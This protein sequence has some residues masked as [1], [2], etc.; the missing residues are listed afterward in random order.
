MIFNN[1]SFMKKINKFGIILSVTNNNL[2]IELEFLIGFRYFGKID[3][4]NDFKY[5]SSIIFVSYINFCGI[6]FIISKKTSRLYEISINKY[7]H[8]FFLE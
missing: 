4:N 1:Y 6:I 8:M 3:I 5:G 7:R 2:K